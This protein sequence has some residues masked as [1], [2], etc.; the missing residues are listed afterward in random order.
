MIAEHGGGLRMI[1]GFC[2]DRGGLRGFVMI[3]RLRRIAVERIARGA[4]GCCWFEGAAGNQL[5]M[6]VMMSSLVDGGANVMLSMP[7]AGDEH[8]TADGD[9]RVKSQRGKEAA[10]GQFVC[11]GFARTLLQT[12]I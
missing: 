10:G 9:I 7:G 8:G 4:R 1:A 3:G 2:D 11:N 6:I 5:I 12:N